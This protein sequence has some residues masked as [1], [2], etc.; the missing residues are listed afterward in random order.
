MA[1]D[2]SGVQPW[3]KG[4][5]YPWT[6]VVV[7]TANGGVIYGQH[8]SGQETEAFAFDGETCFAE[9]HK[10]AESCCRSAA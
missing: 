5:I 2:N 9:A 8:P 1:E 7:S 3:S 6:I 4:E 10:A